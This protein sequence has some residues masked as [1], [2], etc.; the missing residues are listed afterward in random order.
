MLADHGKMARGFPDVRANTVPS[1][2]LGDYEWVLAFEADELYRIVDLMRHLRGSEARMHVREEVPFYT[3]RRKP[4]RR[5]GRGAGVTGRA[6]R[7]AGRTR[8]TQ[9]HGPPPRGRPVAYAVP[10]TSPAAR[11]APGSPAGPAPA[12]RAARSTPGAP[13][14]SRQQIRLDVLVHAG[15]VA[16][17]DAVGARP[18]SRSP[19]RSRAA[20]AAAPARPAYGVAASRSAASSSTGGSAPGSVRHVERAAAAARASRR[21]AGSSRRCPRSRT[22]RSRA[23][24]RVVPVPGPPVVRPGRV[25]A[26]HGGVDGVAVLL[27]LG[28]AGARRGLGDQRLGVAVQIR[29]E[30]R[31]RASASRR[32][33]TRPAGTPP[34]A[35]RRRPC[36]PPARRRSLCARLS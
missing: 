9:H 35:G 36:R 27:G 22:A 17:R 26:L 30:R 18:R 28:A 16:A 4:R 14:S 34:G 15:V 13:G 11:A 31:A 12:P 25:V 19:A 33:C 2:S 21:T 32:R 8:R 29:R 7:P 20:A 10:V 6:V 5:A 3:G 23:S 1:F 24:S